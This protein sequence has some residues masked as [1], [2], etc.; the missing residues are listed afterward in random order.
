MIYFI[1]MIVFSP[2]TAVIP[3]VYAV[4][5]IFKKRLKIEKN[6]WN[7]GLFLLF[8]YSVFSGIINKN[9]LSLLASSV[10]FLYFSLSVFFQNYFVRISRIN[11]VIRYTVYL[12]VI[13]AIGGVIEK[14]IFIL[15]GMPQHRVFSSFGNPNIA[16]AWFGS[17]ILMIFY[18]K[19]I[20]KEKKD[21]II[22]NLS[23]ALVIVALLLTESTGAFI[24]LVGSMFVYY[25]LKEK[26]D[27]RGLIAICIT[28]GISSILFVIIQNKLANTTPIGELVTSFNSRYHIWIGAINMILK[29][30]I[31]GWGILGMMQYGSNFVYS[32]EPSLHNKIIVFLIHPHNLWLTFLVTLGVVGFLIYLY[33][34]FNL[35]KDM[36]KLY[37][38]HNKML[39]LIVAI[40]TMV[41][42]QG[43]V[44]CTLYAP[45]I[46]I[47]FVFIGTITYNMANNKMI[48]KIK[49]SR[50]KKK[51][52]NNKDIAI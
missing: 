31:T 2:F 45:Q 9:L 26:K 44:D 52:N 1:I 8:I 47:I 14:I 24:A 18:L 38:R 27:I 20:D 22:Y 15:I 34:K 3:A 30:T 48:R 29:K 50:N 40:N 36:I 11:I 41:I 32:N 7:I 43:I 6:Y 16:G 21:Y 49:F 33:I 51:E 37:K 25:I 28:V 10:L 19:C 12:S 23:I 17:I 42:I 39:P 35:Y 13:A 46:C 4:N 5:L